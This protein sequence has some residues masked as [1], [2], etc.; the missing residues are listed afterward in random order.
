[1]K[2]IGSVKEDLSQDKR[3]SITPETV[4]KFKNLNFSI[5][6]EKGYG[7]HLG[8]YDNEYKNNGAN[9]KANKKCPQ[10]WQRL[11]AGEGKVECQRWCE[12][13]YH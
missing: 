11:S 1:M 8:I 10:G 9:L 2:I 5:F 6:L 4:K 13:R 7:E 3:I 12:A